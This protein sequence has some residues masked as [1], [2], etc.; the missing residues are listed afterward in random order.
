[1]RALKAIGCLVLLALLATA[2]A[3]WWAWTTLHRPLDPGE[4][5]LV[6]APG[7]DAGTI[8]ARLEE[9]RLIPD[10]RLARAYLVYALGDPPL[11][12][13]EYRFD[14]PLSTRG[15]LDKLI[16]GDVVLH[17]VTV[18]EGLTLEE[19]ADA[20]A[21]AGFGDRAAFVAAMHD[22]SPISD[23]DPDARDLEGYLFPE[24][25][26][27]ARGA[28][29]R[30]I[31]TTMVQTFRDRF[32]SRV[33]PLLE[34]SSASSSD[35]GASGSA[36]EGGAAGFRVPAASHPKSQSAGEDR[37]PDQPVL[38]LSPE[39]SKRGHRRQLTV[40]QLVTLASIVEK[41]AKVDAE[42]PV[43]AAVY[44]NRLET[45][46][47]LYADPTVIFALKL[48]GTWNG[49][50]T[51]EDLRIDS[52]YNTYRFGGLPPGPIA[53]PGLGSLEAAAAP[54]HVGYLYFVSRN[55][56]T[57]VFSKTLAEHNAN[58]RRWQKRYWRDRWAKERKEGKRHR[59]R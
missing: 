54:A 9:E 24:T 32:E 27:F 43:I 30:E 14:T 49:N 46:M 22:P 35:G 18:V 13:G 28:S 47:G 5:T 53:S 26:S 52:P 39:R 57:H 8:L 16:Q 17:R 56:G 58:V 6:V 41:E 7:T 23:L 55:D 44:R 51:R 34:A 36:A 21:H 15:V 3:A 37:P 2:G 12:A 33:R 10:A 48:R 31:V 38:P 19:T 25:Y 42:R 45:G 1:M 59:E 20:L 50:L 11:K 40:R 29:E 4:K